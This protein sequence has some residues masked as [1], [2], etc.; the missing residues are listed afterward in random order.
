MRVDAEQVLEQLRA[1]S[2]REGA[3]FKMKNDPRISKIGALIRR[4]SIDELPQIFNVISGD[5][6]LV[7]PRPSLPIEMVSAPRE[8]LVRL[9]GRPGLTCSWQV[10][11]RAQI[12]YERQCAMDVEYIENPA[13]WTD[14]T[15]MLRTL[16]AVLKA[17]GAY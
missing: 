15:L 10:S 14:I 12:P 9:N 13:F 3:G 7:G 16:P 6:S 8:A 4:Y 17:D 5:M 2:D 1:Q 11:G